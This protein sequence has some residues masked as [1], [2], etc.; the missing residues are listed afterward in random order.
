MP[1]IFIYH[2]CRYSQWKGV[3][4][5]VF[6]HTWVPE[7]EIFRVTYINT[8]ITSVV[9]NKFVNFCPILPILLD[10]IHL[11]VTDEVPYCLWRNVLVFIKDCYIVVKFNDET[12]SL[13]LIVVI[14]TMFSF[15]ISRYSKVIHVLNIS[16]PCSKSS[17]TSRIRSIVLYQVVL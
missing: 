10:I 6:V 9:P 16:R 14:S 7:I 4:Y 15:F 2:L 13:V 5:K 8:F 11:L 1:V 3:T 17:K 12:V